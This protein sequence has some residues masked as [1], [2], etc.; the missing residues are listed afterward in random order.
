VRSVAAITTGRPSLTPHRAKELGGAPTARQLNDDTR[1][2][3]TPSD[4]PRTPPARSRVERKRSS[5]LTRPGATATPRASATPQ[6]T[7]TPGPA[8]TPGAT[9]T[10]TPAAQATATPTATATPAATATPRA[11]TTPAATP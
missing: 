6:A 5:G 2:D 1:L 11:S 4:A 10:A 3:Q 8:A 9:A 7:A